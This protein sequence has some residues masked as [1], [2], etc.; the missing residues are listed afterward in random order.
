M[1]LDKMVPLVGVRGFV[2]AVRQ[3]VDGKGAK[4]SIIPVRMGEIQIDLY[5]M[6]MGGIGDFLDDV[7]VIR[8][9]P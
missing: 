8:G 6:P 7:A 5:V 9:C 3:R 1:A 2:D 4:V